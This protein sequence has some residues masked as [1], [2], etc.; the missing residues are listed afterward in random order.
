MDLIKQMIHKSYLL[1]Y[2]PN[3]SLKNK[4]NNN[5]QIKK[6]R[7]M[8]KRFYWWGC[9]F[10]LSN[11]N[12]MKYDQRIVTID[13]QYQRIIHLDVLKYCINLRHLSISYNNVTSLK[14][15]SSL[16]ELRKLRCN[17]NQIRDLSPH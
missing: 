17:S 4:F 10:K 9:L 11:I 8:L 16:T 1:D 6:A 12:F 5:K 14:F 2:E 15:I 7:A 3:I 13:V